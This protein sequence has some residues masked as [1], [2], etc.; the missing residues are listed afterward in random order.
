MQ[1]IINP[2]NT[3]KD[4]KAYFHQE[5]ANLKIEFFNDRNGDKQVTADEI[6]K[7]TGL[8]LSQFSGKNTEEELR[9]AP[10]MMVNEVEMMFL[11][12]FNVQVQVFRKSG[13]VWLVTTNSDFY[14]LEE[15]NNFADEQQRSANGESEF[16]EE[17]DLDDLD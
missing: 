11:D 4:I 6:E 12:V 3:L 13:N 14:S 2:H 16:E 15:L 10:E 1:L 9:I 8:T 7:Q 5:F 17:I